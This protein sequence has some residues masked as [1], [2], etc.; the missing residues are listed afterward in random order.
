MTFPSAPRTFCS[1]SGPVNRSTDDWHCNGQKLILFYHVFCFASISLLVMTTWACVSPKVAISIIA[2]ATL[3]ILLS[4]YV[5][6]KDRIKPYAVLET[7]QKIKSNESEGSDDYV[8]KGLSWREKVVG[9][10]KITPLMGALCVAYIAQFITIH[11][12]FTTMA[13]DGAPFAPRD[14]FVYY[15]LLNGFGEFI[16]RSYLYV[17]AWLKPEMVSRLIVKQTWIFSTILLTVM[18][19]S[20]CAS[21]YRV[22]NSVWPILLLCF[23]IGSLSG[24][25]FANTVCAVPV[26]VEPKYREFCLGL[27]GLGESMGVLIASFSGIAV[28]PALRKHCM[29]VIS[30]HDLCYTRHETLK[31]AS[32]VCSRNVK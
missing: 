27:V 5:L 24:L 26:V 4:Y 19:F 16:T 31:W 12:V 11:A 28:E 22:F 20:I 29:R 18:I 10:W 17:V 14:H 1:E 23:I 30:Q 8:H 6:D 13:F 2:P 7:Y 15:V 25:V 3:V 9:A 32:S 21:Y